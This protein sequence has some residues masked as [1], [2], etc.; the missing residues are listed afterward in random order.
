MS[1][2]LNENIHCTSQYAIIVRYPIVEK[3]GSRK[4]I[5]ETIIYHLTLQF[6][7]HNKSTM[8]VWTMGGGSDNVL[9]N[10]RLVPH[11]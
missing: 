3:T 8:S 7:L 2:K 6:T 11:K 9:S 5:N 1:E 10:Y 4:G